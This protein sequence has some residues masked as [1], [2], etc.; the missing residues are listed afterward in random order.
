MTKKINTVNG[1]KN[2]IKNPK[3]YVVSLVTDKG[4][5]VRT[6]TDP[7]ETIAEISAK[8]RIIAIQSIIDID[9]ASCNYSYRPVFTTI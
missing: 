2:M 9:A 6:T 1:E 5:V 4:A 8:N 7:N 3:R